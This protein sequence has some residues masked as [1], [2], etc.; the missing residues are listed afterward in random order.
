MDKI[1]SKQI[2]WFL[3]IAYLVHLADEYFTGFSGWFSALLNVNLSVNDFILINSIGFAATVIISILYILNKAN[4]FIIGT[5]GTLFF[6]NGLLHITASA[7]TLNYSPGTISGL[8]IYIP[9]G[10]SI[11]K[12]IFPLIPEQQ[13]ILCIGA[14]IAVQIFVA[15]VALNI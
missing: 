3:P 1:S 7:F 14:A 9:L 10:Y 13:R 8:L 11:F 2:A 6:T 15:L 5:L 12:K 4:N